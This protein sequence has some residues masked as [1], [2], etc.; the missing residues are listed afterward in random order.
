MQRTVDVATFAARLVQDSALFV[1]SFVASCRTKSLKN[2][3]ER[4]VAQLL[5]R[6]STAS[7]RL[8]KAMQPITTEKTSAVIFHSDS[9]YSTYRKKLHVTEKLMGKSSDSLIP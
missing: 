8:N 4:V 9:V 6:Q 3:L 7:F 2:A 5:V 1:V